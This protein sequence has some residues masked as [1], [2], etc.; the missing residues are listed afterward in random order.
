MYKPATIIE[1]SA[2]TTESEKQ[3]IEKVLYEIFVKY[4]IE[5]SC[6]GLNNGIQ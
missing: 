4:F 6:R 2:K 1:T 5:K 3:Y